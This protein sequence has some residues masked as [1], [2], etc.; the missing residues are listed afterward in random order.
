MIAF[1]VAI[2]FV[3]SFF[4]KEEA[5]KEVVEGEESLIVGE[6]ELDRD[7]YEKEVPVPEKPTEVI[8]KSEELEDDYLKEQT[9]S[10]EMSKG[11]VT[12]EL[13]VNKELSKQMEGSIYKRVEKEVIENE[14]G[15]NFTFSKE[16]VYLVDSNK[17]Y[18]EFEVNL[19]WHTDDGTKVL[20]S[21]EALFYVGIKKDAE[22]NEWKVI[23]FVE[24]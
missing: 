23:K 16:D 9:L 1:F 13:F 10:L 21:V 15:I 14:L 4:T 20:A 3:S 11:F 5:P 2:T 17:D 8:E 19:I 12:G 6:V 18:L 22:D 24:V 7:K